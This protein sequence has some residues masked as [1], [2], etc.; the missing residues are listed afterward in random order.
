M[1]A[2][3]NEIAHKSSQALEL[4]IFQY[5]FEEYANDSYVFIHTNNSGQNYIVYVNQKKSMDMTASGTQCKSKKKKQ[6]REH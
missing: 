2:S 1:Q 6:S 5:R 3:P 4:E